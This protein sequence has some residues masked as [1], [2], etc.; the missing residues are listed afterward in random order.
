[1]HLMTQDARLLLSRAARTATRYFQ[2]R[3]AEVDLSVVQGQALMELD[4]DPGMTVGAMAAA[5]SKD[6]AS[7]S[8]L[9][10]KLMSLGLVRRET[11][12]TDRRRARLFLASQAEPLVRHLELAR[13]DINRLVL[14]ALGAQRSRA[15]MS[16]LADFLDAV[17]G[18][19]ASSEVNSPL[20]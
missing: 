12:P 3:A 15:L 11:D 4:A 2:E 7:T 14:D 20:R 10:D 17:E 19:E 13:D 8:I 9:V 18:S 16:L 1:M 6:Q 5:L